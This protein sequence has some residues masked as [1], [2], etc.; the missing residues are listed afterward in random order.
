MIW[1]WTSASVVRRRGSTPSVVE[2]V[3]HRRRRDRDGASTGPESSSTHSSIVSIWTPIATVSG[4]LPISSAA[5]KHVD[6][7]HVVQ[8]VRDLV[9]G[10]L[11]GRQY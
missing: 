11:L 4:A 3:E 2:L 5:C 1:A 7:S 8:R 6:E 10:D 9:R